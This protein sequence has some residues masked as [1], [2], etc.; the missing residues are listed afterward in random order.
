M[1][2]E[3]KSDRQDVASFAVGVG[4]PAVKEGEAAYKLYKPNTGPAWDVGIPVS[5]LLC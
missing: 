4:T 1:V 5:N 2:Q 3:L